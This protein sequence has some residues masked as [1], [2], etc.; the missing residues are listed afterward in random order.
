MTAPVPYSPS[1][2][3]FLRQGYQPEQAE[4][5]AGLKPM[6][7]A[8]SAPPAPAAKPKAKA[9]AKAKVVGTWAIR[10]WARGEGIAV[11]SRGRIPRAVVERYDA[12]HPL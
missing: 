4:R 10:A 8:P 6:L 3:E 11:P 1:V 12:T 5:L 7:Q 2:Q 9:A